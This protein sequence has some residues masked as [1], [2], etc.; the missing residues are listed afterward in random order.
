MADVTEQLAGDTQGRDQKDSVGNR[1]R[2]L[3]EGIVRLQTEIDEHKATITLLE[4]K[5]EWM[6]KSVRVG[7]SLLAPIR[8]VPREILFRIFSARC[9][10]RSRLDILRR[11]Y[12]VTQIPQA[13]QDWMEELESVRAGKSMQAPIRRIPHDILRYI[14]SICC[15]GGTKLEMPRWSH[16]QRPAP[17]VLSKVCALWRAT[18]ISHRTLWSDLHF[19]FERVGIYEGKRCL[20]ITKMFLERAGNTPLRLTFRTTNGTRSPELT[21]TF[22]DRLLETLCA[23]ASQW[24]SIRFIDIP[25][26]FVRRSAF[27]A[28]MRT[29]LR[30]L[31]TIRVDEL[32]SKDPFFTL[33]FLGFQEGDE[34]KQHQ[35]PALRNAE[36]SLRLER[37]H[38]LPVPRIPWSQLV[39]LTLTTYSAAPTPSEILPLCSSLTEL[40]ISMYGNRVLPDNDFQHT[41]PSLRSLTITDICRDSTIFPHF[42]R[43]FT[44]PQ[45]ISLNIHAARTG[46]LLRDAEMTPLIDF[47]VS[48]TPSLVALSLVCSAGLHV[49]QACHLLQHLPN[50]TSLNLHETFWHVHSFRPRTTFLL[51]QLIRASS[52]PSSTV[53]FLPHLSDLTI[54]LPSEIFYDE[55]LELLGAAVRSRSISSRELAA[56]PGVDYLRS[57]EVQLSEV[58][59]LRLPV[60][61]LRELESLRDEGLRVKLPFLLSAGEGKS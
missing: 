43:L 29:Q 26:S 16:V 32:D 25:S 22:T 34:D 36:L 52:V 5:Q 4:A 57:V 42:L 11:I 6:K 18:A 9:K 59:T 49:Q 19:I 55:H 21:G 44:F 40:K 17:I 1:V 54:T 2:E 20:R 35:C 13:K 53:D 33:D 28:V 10:G 51:K 24:S 15:E 31:H 47:L 48:S 61:A 8:R 60:E 56:E 23:R 30:N 27:G 50:L 46:S 7:R 12:E 58:P 41:L 37:P 3:E 39:S 14:F 38:D 45:L